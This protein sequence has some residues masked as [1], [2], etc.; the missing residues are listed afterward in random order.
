MRKD[1]IHQKNIISALQ[2]PKVLQLLC[3]NESA[4]KN[5]L[6]KLFQFCAQKRFTSQRNSCLSRSSCAQKLSF[7][8]YSSLQIHPG[9]DILYP[10][11][12]SQRPCWPIGP[13]INLDKVARTDRYN[14]IQLTYCS[15]KFST[16]FPY[17]LGI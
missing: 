5:S 7:L 14:W 10:L 12:S 2:L 6:R 3:S 11:P 8:F 13:T 4:L 1:R 15:L 9:L 17:I 16:T